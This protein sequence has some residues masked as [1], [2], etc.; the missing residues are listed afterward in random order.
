[1]MHIKLYSVIFGE[2]NNYGA[3]G[4]LLHTV[5]PQVLFKLTFYFINFPQGS[6]DSIT[7]LTIT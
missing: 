3:V 4:D 7:S 5:T 2:K 6:L 1:M